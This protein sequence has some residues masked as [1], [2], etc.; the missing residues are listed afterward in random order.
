MM[1]GCT[2]VGHGIPCRDGVQWEVVLCV[3]H[4]WTV[5]TFWSVL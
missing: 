2:N 4:V 5:A 1:V 3:T